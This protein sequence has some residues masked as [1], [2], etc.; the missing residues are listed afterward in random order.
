[1]K[2]IRYADLVDGPRRGERIR[3]PWG[4]ASIRFAVEQELV[5]S[6]ALPE[7]ATPL[8]METI[9][10]MPMEAGENLIGRNPEIGDFQIEQWS[11]GGKREEYQ[12]IFWT[13]LAESNRQARLEEAQ[14][15][16][17]SNGWSY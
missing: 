17:D 2:P 9:T 11:V 14:R 16:I 15:V 8:L 10:Y 12:R 4:M 6:F 5:P 3:V 7:E 13:M 1:M